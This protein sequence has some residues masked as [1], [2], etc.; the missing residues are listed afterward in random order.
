[1]PQPQHGP[2]MSTQE[3]DACALT[4]APDLV[5][6]WVLDCEEKLGMSLRREE[7]VPTRSQSPPLDMKKYAACGVYVSSIVNVGGTLPS[8]FIA[9]RE[10]LLC[11]AGNTASL[12]DCMNGISR[13]Q[14]RQTAGLSR[15]L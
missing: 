2:I 8:L 10:A 12:N 5:R 14:R 1:M 3:I 15:H 6:P 7:E 9:S 11:I 4:L 13:A